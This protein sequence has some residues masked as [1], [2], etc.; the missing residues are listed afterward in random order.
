MRNSSRNLYIFAIYELLN[1]TDDMH[2]HGSHGFGTVN[3]CCCPNH[4][5][6]AK[7]LLSITRST[8]VHVMAD[9]HAEA[10]TIHQV[11]HFWT[12]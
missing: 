5:A 2:S 10:A 7:C 1:G 8:K 3:F 11:D 9:E 6:I 4:W 12:T